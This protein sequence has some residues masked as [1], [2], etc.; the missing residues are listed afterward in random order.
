VQ[1]HKPWANYVSSYCKFPAV[2]GSKNYKKILQVWK[3][4]YINIGCNMTPDDDDDDE[5]VGD[6]NVM[7]LLHHSAAGDGRYVRLSQK[8]I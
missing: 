7:L 3:F 2:Y 6:K 1:L 4:E 8:M 5:C